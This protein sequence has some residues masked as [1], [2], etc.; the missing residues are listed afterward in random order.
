MHFLVA[1]QHQTCFEGKTPQMTWGDICISLV[2]EMKNRSCLQILI[3]QRSDSFSPKIT[4]KVIVCLEGGHLFIPKEN[5]ESNMEMEYYTAGKLDGIQ[6][7]STT[8]INLRNIIC[9]ENC[10][11][12]P[13]HSVILF[14]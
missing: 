9:S 14:L 5:L 6:L 7:Y 10:W 8:R 3:L 13:P 1:M 2:G 4:Q 12:Q 11:L